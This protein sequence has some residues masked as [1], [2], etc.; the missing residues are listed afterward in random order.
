MV[1]PISLLFEHYP[2]MP[3]CAYN[4]MQRPTAQPTAPPTAGVHCMTVNFAYNDTRRGINKVSLLP[5]SHWIE[6]SS[7]GLCS[8]YGSS[9]VVREWSF[10]PQSL[11]HCT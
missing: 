9:V 3:T 7:N 6:Y 5:K 1:L 2:P 8:A 10:Y 4:M 11:L